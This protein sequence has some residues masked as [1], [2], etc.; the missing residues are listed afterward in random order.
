MLVCA[1]ANDAFGHASSI[2][3]GVVVETVIPAPIPSKSGVPTWPPSA[4]AVAYNKDCIM[5]PGL[6]SDK[7]TGLSFPSS[8]HAYWGDLDEVCVLRLL[9]RSPTP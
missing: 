1:S 2:R 4:G 6:G 7:P 5:V 8:D 3:L 9:V